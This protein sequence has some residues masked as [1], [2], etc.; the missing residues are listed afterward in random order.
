[1][2]DAPRLGLKIL[3][4]VENDVIGAGRAGQ[5]RLGFGGNRPNDPR[6]TKVRDLAEQLSGSTGGSMDQTGVSRGQRE[7]RACQIMSCYALEHRSG[8][9]PG[10]D[11]IRQDDQSLRASKGELCI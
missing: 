11:S 3:L 10:R 9:N 8:S 1:M 5:C 7:S 4:G 2:G 6:S